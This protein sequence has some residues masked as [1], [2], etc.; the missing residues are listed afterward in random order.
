VNPGLYLNTFSFFSHNF[1]T[2]LRSPDPPAAIHHFAIE[3]ITLLK[4]PQRERLYVEVS[5][6]QH[7]PP[8]TGLLCIKCTASNEYVPEY[9]SEHS[10]SRNVLDAILLAVE[11]LSE[12]SASRQPLV[13]PIPTPSTFD[14]D[15]PPSSASQLTLVDPEPPTS[16]HTFYRSATSVTGQG[17]KKNYEPGQVVRQIKPKGL[18]LF[19]LALLADTVHKQDRLYSLFENQCYWYTNLIC[20]AVVTLYTCEQQ[21]TREATYS[22][23]D[24]YIPPNDRFP[25]LAGQCMRILVSNVEAV[26]L[27][28]VLARFKEVRTQKMD[29]VSVS[30]WN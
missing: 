30:I 12:P 23:D 22:Q 8:R 29:A 27:S 2:V 10:D 9:F 6:T 11:D 13:D 28:V 17:N 4:N 1:D 25:K 14:S 16:T 26:V 3:S 20:D 5:D 15:P 19:E 18:N 7:T 24:V 21:D